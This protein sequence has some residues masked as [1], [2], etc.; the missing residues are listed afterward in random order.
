MTVEERYRERYKSGDTP[1]D[2]GQPDFNLIEVVTKKPILRSLTPFLHEQNMDDEK[3]ADQVKADHLRSLGPELGPVFSALSN[4]LAWLQ[5]SN[6]LVP[7]L[8]A[9]H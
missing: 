7:I 6:S 1:W 4:D 9:G 5:V 2:V 3:T 8:P